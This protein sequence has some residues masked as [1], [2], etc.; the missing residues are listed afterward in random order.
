ML[1]C[2]CKVSGHRIEGEKLDER[3][4]SHRLRIDWKLVFIE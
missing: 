1:A 3:S 4:T 2:S